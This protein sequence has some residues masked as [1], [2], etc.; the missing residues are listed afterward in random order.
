[1]IQ[2]HCDASK[3]EIQAAVREHKKALERAEKMVIGSELMAEQA[4]QAKREFK[5]LSLGSAEDERGD[6]T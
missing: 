2:K 3:D 4:K 1:M 6:G 5:R